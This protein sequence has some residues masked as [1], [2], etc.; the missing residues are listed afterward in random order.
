MKQVRETALGKNL[1]RA[2]SFPRSERSLVR[3]AFPCDL[4]PSRKIHMSQSASCQILRVSLIFL[5]A[6]ATQFDVTN[7]S[8]F[9]KKLKTIR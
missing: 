8:G 5:S 7:V 9:E 3:R 6:T 4:D 1:I 2:F